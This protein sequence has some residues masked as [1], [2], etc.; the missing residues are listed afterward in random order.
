MIGRVEHVRECR[1]ERNG[2]PDEAVTWVNVENESKIG[3]S[4]GAA[5]QDA[6]KLKRN[7]P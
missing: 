7:K 4:E 2:R 5:V 3:C 6:Q 1:E